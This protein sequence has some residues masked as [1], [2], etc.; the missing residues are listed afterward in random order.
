MRGRK[1][2]EVKRTLVTAA[3]S[4]ESVENKVKEFG[5]SP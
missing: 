3:L 1:A 2:K 4:R 5:I